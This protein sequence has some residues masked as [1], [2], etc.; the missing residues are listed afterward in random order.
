MLHPILQSYFKKF[1]GK[2]ACLKTLKKRGLNILIFYICFH[3]S[4]ITFF[5]YL[6]FISLYILYTIIN[7]IK[8]ITISIT[9]S[10]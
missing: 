2:K 6:F 7:K 1:E 5:T 8:G 9:A 10:K 3:L 4:Y